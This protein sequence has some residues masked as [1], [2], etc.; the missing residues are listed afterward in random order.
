MESIWYYNNGNYLST[1][2]KSITVETGSKNEKSGF[3]IFF[4]FWQT[5][6]NIFWMREPFFMKIGKHIDLTITYILTKVQPV[7][8]SI[9]CVTIDFRWNG[10][11]LIFPQILNQFFRQLKKIHF[12]LISINPENFRL[13]KKPEGTFRKITCT[14]SWPYIKFAMVQL[15]HP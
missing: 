14:M 3:L 8:I 6:V 15:V 4:H 5:F 11:Y 2:D 1:F 12:K 7:K 10:K 13:F 9:F